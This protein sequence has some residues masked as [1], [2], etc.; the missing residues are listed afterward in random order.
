MI[1]T[2]GGRP[3]SMWMAHF[4]KLGL[5]SLHNRRIVLDH[6]G[7]KLVLAGIADRALIGSTILST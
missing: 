1:E 4:T 2:T 3:Y 5:L 6:N 7:G